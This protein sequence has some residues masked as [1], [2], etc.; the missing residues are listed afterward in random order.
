MGF[1]KTIKRKYINL[2]NGKGFLIKELVINPRSSISLQKHKFRA[3]HWTV[4]SG[5]PLITINRKKFIK[6]INETILVPKGATHRI[7][8]PNNIP[9]VIMEVQKGS[10][11]KES[12]IVRY[13]DIYGR[14][15]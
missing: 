11:L 12:D 7:E 2:F 6:K 13:K 10:I 5:N 1:L 3:E 8:N 9:V 14:V 4:V 15:K